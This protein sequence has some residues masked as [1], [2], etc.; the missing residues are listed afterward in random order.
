MDDK[1]IYKNVSKLSN[2]ELKAY[3][4]S[5][6]H[7]MCNPHKDLTLSMKHYGITLEELDKRGFPKQMP[8]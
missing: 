7:D 8:F 6:E 5:L 4:R 3:A 1:V 2:F